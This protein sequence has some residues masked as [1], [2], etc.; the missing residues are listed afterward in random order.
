MQDLPARPSTAPIHRMEKHEGT[1]E[2][3]VSEDVPNV[4]MDGNKAH[5][6]KR[7]VKNANESPLSARLRKQASSASRNIT[8]RV[9]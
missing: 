9:I 4:I 2:I 6:D 5:L 8:E 7:L 1:I 3:A